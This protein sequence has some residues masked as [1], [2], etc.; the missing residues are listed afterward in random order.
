L[1][2]PD[3]LK[4]EQFSLQVV[5]ENRNSPVSRFG[6]KQE[7]SVEEWLYSE[8]WEFEFF[9][10]VRIL[11]LLHHDRV[12]AGEAANPQDEAVRFRSLVTQVFPASEVQSIEPG[13]H[14]Q[15]VVTANLFPV[16]GAG[17]PLPAPDG[18]R[19]IEQTWRKDH[20]MRDFLDMFH[21]R[22]LSLLVRSRKMHHPAYTSRRPHDGP[23]AS[24]L[25]AFFGMALDEVRH[26]MRISDRA[27]VF[28]SG[29]LAQQPRSAS[30]LERLL[31]DYFQVPAR[32]EQLLGQWRSLDAEEWTIIGTRGRNQSL[33]QG[34]LLGCRVWDQ[35][36][37]FEV[38]LGPMR[39]D[40]FLNLLPCGSGFEPLCELTRFYVGPDPEFGFRMIVEGL[41][42]AP[43]VLGTSR[44]GW[45]SWLKTRPAAGLD[46]QVRLASRAPADPYARRH[47]REVLAN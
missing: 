10:A 20:A 43:A 29:L 27:L 1:T 13:E 18:E 22:L 28:Y 2:S 32:V 25:Y 17:G 41:D 38:H 42:T 35:Q 45:T 39:L 36:G 40:A 34:A 5:S 3:V 21:H 31:S 8:P 30:G 4:I 9:Q 46:S 7:A 14:D 24:Y 19:V 23:I 37:R 15:P 44:L 33:G 6:W 47:I 16:A 26:R 12:P 11:E